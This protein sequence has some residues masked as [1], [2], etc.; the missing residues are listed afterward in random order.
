MST[1]QNIKAKKQFLQELFSQFDTSDNILDLMTS[2]TKF[3]DQSLRTHWQNAGL[4]NESQLSLIALGSYG[5]Y[6]LLPYSDID[7]LILHRDNISY[8][9]LE[10]IETFIQRLWDDGF[11]VGHSVS[12]ISKSIEL[13]TS[14]IQ[15]IS[16]LMDMRLILGNMPLYDE[17]R[18]AISPHL[19]W[20]SNVFFK[21]KWK[22]Q[23][24]RYK[25]FNETAY[26]LEPNIK[27][28]PGG[29][30]DLQ[31][32]LWIAKRHYG[33]NNFA[34]CL[35]SGLITLEEYHTLT[36]CQQFLWRVRFALHIVAQRPEDRILFNYQKKL[37]KI[38]G[39][40]NPNVNTAIEN[41]M[42][43]YFTIVKSV[44]ELNDLLLQL[45]RETVFSKA[46]TSIKNISTKFQIT[47]DYI[48]VKHINTFKQNPQSLF[49]LFLLM[50]EYPEIKGVRANT[51]RLLRK[52]SYLV[53]ERFRHNK[54]NT[55]AFIQL[56]KE[57]KNIFATLK[58]MNRYGLLR[59]YIPEFSYVIGQ[60]QYD[61]FHVYTVDQHSLFVVRNLMNFAK[62]S[63]AFP[64]CA[65]VM[66][67]IEKKE[68]L[69][70][71][72][73]FH[74]IGKGRGGDHSTI[75]AKDAER[76]CQRHRLSKEDTTLI[77]WMV[78]EHL[79]MSH[80]AQRKDIDEISTI[81]AFCNNVQSKDYLNHLYL[82]T[83]AD[84]CATNPTLW[85]NWK[86]TLLRTLYNKAYQHL[87]KSE[88]IDESTLISNRK[89][90]A[91]ALLNAIKKETIHKLWHD[92][93]GTYFLHEPADVIAEQTRAILNAR[94][95]PLILITP[96]HTGSGTQVMIYTPHLKE[97][98]SITTNIFSNFNL[99]IVEAR[100]LTL[101]NNFDLDNYII[102]DTNNQALKSGKL[103]EQ[104]KQTLQNHLTPPITIP[105]PTK[106]LS[107]RRQKHL[108]LAPTITFNED[109]AKR[110]TLLFL[111]ASDREG[112][113]ASISL[114]FSKHNLLLHNAKIHTTGER[115]EDTFFITDAK[116]EPLTQSTQEK[117][118]QALIKTL[119]H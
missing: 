3:S 36:N 76:F 7:L 116:N 101:K 114:V 79:L 20:P 18:Y 33:D 109:H 82:L 29:L 12:T 65:E 25:K 50:K 48:E 108:L 24:K 58:R 9:A 5:R 22:E 95:H 68:I 37:T 61:L 44:R 49:E 26:N 14:D 81:E 91:I 105:K 57:E 16:N 42:K 45:F 106:R 60:M 96:H 85:N 69:Y 15:V 103:I 53:D 52:Y 107:S 34:S 78:K 17:M 38:L 32:I 30:R 83:I 6:E 27:N 88:Y 39:Y 92:F 75:G 19:M 99:N 117:L 73:L 67:L 70:I 13:A 28:G 1:S 110:R 118:A 89:K 77:T 74:D 104:L 43:V 21:E 93:K 86:A 54:K 66:K 62:N 2:L 115:V 98:F 100:I 8:T 11:H 41:F 80:T 84:I 63:D 47:N 35:A 31:M 56:L 71:A 46:K 119:S 51:I 111:L 94:V 10:K 55:A 64:H 23:L 40:M 4:I 97:R 113:L 87:D 112:L 72:A 102:L 59:R 90:D